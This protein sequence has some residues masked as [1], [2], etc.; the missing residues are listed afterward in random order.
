[1]SNLAFQTTRILVTKLDVNLAKILDELF[2]FL[3]TRVG[4]PSPP[5][6]H[7]SIVWNCPKI[8]NWRTGHHLTQH[9]YSNKTDLGQCKVIVADLSRNIHKL[10]SYHKGHYRVKAFFKEVALILRKFLTKHNLTFS[11]QLVNELSRNYW[12]DPYKRWYPVL[13]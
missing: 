3:L 1:M 5:K 10:T 12:Q 2:L 13:G 11:K 6:I 7:W 9:Y 8:K 4:S